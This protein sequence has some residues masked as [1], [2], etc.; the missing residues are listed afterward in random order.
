MHPATFHNSSPLSLAGCAFFLRNWAVGQATQDMVKSCHQQAIGVNSIVESEQKLK[1]LNLFQQRRDSLDVKRQHA[2]DNEAGA[3]LHEGSTIAGSAIM[4]EQ[5]Q[6]NEIEA[7]LVRRIADGDRKAFE[8]LFN[9]Y[10]KRIFRYAYRMINDTGKAEEV[11]NDVMIEVWKSAGKFEER[12][13]VSTWIIGITRFRAL[14]AIRG[15]RVETVELESAPEAEDEQANV[16]QAQDRKSLNKAIRQQLTKL[17]PEHRDVI[18]L[19]FFHGHSYKEIAEIAGC[20]E[21]TIKTR[22]FHAKKQLEPLLK[23]IGVE[24]YL[25]EVML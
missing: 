17:S 5:E 2:S 23:A 8:E 25:T 3:R 18:E 6:V 9:V 20:P 14:N 15:K 1:N 13:S 7:R 24:S 12:S 19:T 22:M 16:E 4:S 10:G 11:T 21:N